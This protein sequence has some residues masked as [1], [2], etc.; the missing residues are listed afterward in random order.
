MRN[1][2]VFSRKE[3]RLKA[4]F[5]AGILPFA[6]EEPEPLPFLESIV[7][8]VVAKTFP[9]WPTAGME[10]EAMRR[11]TNRFVDFLEC[12]VGEGVCCP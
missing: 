8:K 4:V 9:E 6:L 1:S 3:V 10:V 5:R 7:E 11:S 12:K 2:L